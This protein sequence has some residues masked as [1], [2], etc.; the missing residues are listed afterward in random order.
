LVV[1]HFVIMF[2][3]L[4]CSFRSFLILPYNSFFWDCMSVAICSME[5][6]LDGLDF[7]IGHC[8]KTCRVHFSVLFGRP[9]FCYIVIEKLTF[10]YIDL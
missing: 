6:F 3:N 1:G 4:S 9:P 8:F 7:V 2:Y 5:F 10:F